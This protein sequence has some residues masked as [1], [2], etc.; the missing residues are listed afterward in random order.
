MEDIDWKAIYGL[1]FVDQPGCWTSGCQSYCCTHKSDHLSFSLLT[2]GAGMVFFEQEYDFLTSIGRHQ[3]GFEAASRRMKFE[4]EPGLELKFVLSKCALNGI[5]TIHE[6]RPLCCKVY[7]FL[8]RVDPR[9]SEITGFMSGT[10]FDVF[11]PVI[12]AQHPCTLVRTK[13]EE[14]QEQERG[15]LTRLLEHP[16]LLF[17]FRALELFLTSVSE[18]VKRLHDS[19]PAF[20][21]QALSKKWELLYLTGKAFDVERLR[22]DILRD[23]RIIAGRFPGLTI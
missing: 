1:T 23:Y 2:G 9:T 19:N 8:P 5:C 20:T 17:Y 11:W 16:Y 7:P 4:I 13:P 3:A 21:S 12:G 18:G 10:V 6:F 22:T 14:V 15:P